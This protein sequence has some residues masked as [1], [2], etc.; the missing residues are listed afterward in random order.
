MDTVA[1]M[2]RRNLGRLIMVVWIIALGWLARRQLFQG[3]ASTLTASAS[4]LSPDAKYFRVDA[5]TLQIGVLNLTWD[6]LPTGFRVE[7]LLA[8]DLPYEEG[9]RRQLA[10]TEVITSRG[11]TLQS[12]S[13]RMSTPSGSQTRSVDL[14]VDS[15]QRYTTLTDQGYGPAI[16]RE[17]PRPTVAGILPLRLAYGNRLVAGEPIAERVADLERRTTG[18]IT[19]TVL[20]DTTFVLPDSVDYDSVAH[21]WRTI[22]LDTL[23]AWHLALEVGGLPEQWWVDDAGRLVRLETLFG[24]TL[25]RSPFDYSH[26]L[27]RDSLRLSGPQP[28]R[29]LAGVGTLASSGVRLDTTSRVMRFRVGRVDRPLDA[30][31][32]ARLAGGAQFASGDTLTIRRDWPTGTASPP[33]GYLAPPR[34]QREPT[35]VT[36]IE[37]DSAFAGATSAADSAMRL[38]R[39][40]AGRVALDTGTVR[41]PEVLGARRSRT[42]TPSAMAEFLVSL[43]RAGGIPARVVSGLAVTPAGLFSHAWAEV[44]VG[45][46]WVPVDPTSGHAP[47]SARLLRITEGGLGRPFETLWRTAALRVEPLTPGIR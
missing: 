47:A 8:L 28:R 24:V 17:G 29:G 6:T 39:W 1:G 18:M 19:G 44:W 33:E 46:N 22:T 38:T 2:S 31:A 41:P 43:A 40:V 9:I 13:V 34:G 3:E 27:F 42:G 14:Q 45:D 23:H 30:A 7:E 5:G 15:L 37:A 25:Q 36:R 12:A 16:R 35:G 11:L 10:L 32:V 21:A 26:T 4:R 20:G